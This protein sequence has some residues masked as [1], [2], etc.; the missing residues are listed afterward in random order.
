MSDYKVLLARVS[1]LTRTVD[2]CQRELRVLTNDLQLHPD[3]PLKTFERDYLREFLSGALIEA[4]E[5]DN[6]WL[7]GKGFQ[8]TIGSA[9]FAYF[10]VAGWILPI[11]F[12]DE[13]SWELSDKA[14]AYLSLPSIPVK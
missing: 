13:K 5:E 12:T 9:T 3:R 2:D 10:K 14:R 11:P 7:V 8:W 1:A 6:I 4:R